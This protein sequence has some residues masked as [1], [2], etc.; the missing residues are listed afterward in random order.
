MAGPDDPVHHHKKDNDQVASQKVR[1]AQRAMDRRFQLLCLNIVLE[2]VK[3]QRPSLDI[4]DKDIE[5]LGA[6]ELCSALDTRDEMKRVPK[7]LMFPSKQYP[8]G[9]AMMERV[10]VDDYIL[11]PINVI[12]VTDKLAIAMSLGHAAGGFDSS[13]GL[14]DVQAF[15]GEI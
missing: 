15:E 4:V 14:P 1:V 12:E 3:A 13:T 7:I 2:Q 9:M 8:E 11:K 5:P 10:G 6:H